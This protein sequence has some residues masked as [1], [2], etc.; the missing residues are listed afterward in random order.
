MPNTPFAYDKV[1]PRARAALLSLCALLACASAAQAQ[2]GNARKPAPQSKA[3]E[4]PTPTRS[5]TSARVPQETLLQIVQAEDERRWED[6]DLSK[7]LTD[8][9]PSVRARAALAAGRIGDEGAVGPLG[10]MLYGDRDD[11]VRAAAAFALGEIEAEP[12]SGALTEA[13]RV[14]KSPEVRA[15]AVEALGKI[16]AALPEARADAKKRI[17]DAITTALTAEQRL[18]KPNRALVLLGLTALLRARPENGAR[19]V[20]LFLSSSDARARADAA[21]ALGRMRAKES[22]ER[23]RAMLATDTDAVARANAARALGAA[24]DAAS[25]EVLAQHVATDADARVRVSAVRSLAQIKEP[26]AADALITARRR[27][28]RRLQVGA[29]GRRPEPARGQ[30]A[31]GS[32]DRDGTRAGELERRTFA[33]AFARGARG[34]GG[35]ARD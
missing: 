25:F 22:L 5:R 16:A 31:F 35:R 6:S 7:L 32:R 20:A 29:R 15:R 27:A 8:A 34:R 1:C 30:R 10:A 23:L 19:T 12:A 9:S 14:S 11:S 26:R 18:T 24:E 4:K 33:D 21:N 2:R 13:L 28:V 17:G 3:K